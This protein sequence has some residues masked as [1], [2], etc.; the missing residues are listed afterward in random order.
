MVVEQPMVVYYYWVELLLVV[1]DLK[2]LE[3]RVEMVYYY[4]EAL[5]QT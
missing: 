4:L 2:T 3:R 1:A 5:E